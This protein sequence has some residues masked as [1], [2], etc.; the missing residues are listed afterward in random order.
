[1]FLDEMQNEDN[2]PTVEAAAAPQVPQTMTE[3]LGEMSPQMKVALLIIL[4]GLIMLM[5]MVY[6]N[7]RQVN[8]SIEA[9]GQAQAQ[10]VK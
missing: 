3:W 2:Q 1:M 4:A 10:W 9:I 5:L 7:S 8:A 6:Q